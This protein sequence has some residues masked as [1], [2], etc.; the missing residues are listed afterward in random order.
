MNRRLSQW[1]Y[2]YHKKDLDMNKQMGQ[3]KLKF[4]IDQRHMIRM[5]VQFHYIHHMYHDIIGTQ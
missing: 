5:L 4:F 3:L 2:F 1:H